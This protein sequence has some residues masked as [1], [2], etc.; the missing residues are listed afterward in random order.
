[1]KA[2]GCAEIFPY[3]RV[4]DGADNSFKA[5]IDLPG[6]TLNIPN[7]EF[8]S[9][10]AAGPRTLVAPTASAPTASAPAAPVVT[11]VASATAAPSPVVSLVY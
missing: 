10:T 3:G 1:V 4:E 6:A 2:A 7:H 8:A 9:A 5:K 11:K